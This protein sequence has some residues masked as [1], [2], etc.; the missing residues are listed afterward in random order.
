MRKIT[1]NDFFKNRSK[2]SK[3]WQQ[4]LAIGFGLMVGHISSAQTMSEYDFTQSSGTYTPLSGATVLWSG[5]DGFDDDA[6]TINLTT[7]FN[8]LGTNYSSI[9]VSAN[10]NIKFGSTSTT[11]TVISSGTFYAVA[12]FAVD[13]DAKAASAGTDLPSVSWKEEG[14]EVIIQWAN[15]CRYAT[16]GA[17][18]TS[19]ENL[20]FQ[21]RLNTSNSEIK[22][23]YGA[24]TDRVTPL[25]ST[26]PQV[27]LAGGSATSYSNRTIA[28]GGG[29]WI[30]STAGTA[31]GNTMAF[32]GSTIPS[33]GLT[34]KWTLPTCFT[35][36]GLTATTI[37]KNSALLQ[38]NNT[39]N[40]FDVEWGIEGFTPTNTPTAGYANIAG[41]S[42]TVS[43]LNYSTSYEYYLR[44]NC[45]DEGV[46]NWAGPYKFTTLC[47]YPDITNTTPGSV[48][49]LGEVNL[50]VS[51][52]A[53]LISWYNAPI[54]GVKLGEGN[55]FVTPTID[56]TTSYYVQVG[57]VTPGVITQVGNGTT[58]S[59][60]GGASP[61][62]RNWGGF[63]TQNI[64]RA[65]E[66]IAAGVA[67]GEIT[68]L[69]V[70]VTVAPTGNFN[71]LTI[72]VGHTT[73][74]VAT[75]THVDYNTLQLVY[76]NAS[77]SFTTGINT[78][79]FTQPFT[80]DGESNIV[81]QYN[82]SNEDS[83]S[84]SQ[85]KTIRYNNP[86]F[87]CTTYTYADGRTAD[88]ILNTLTGGVSNGSTTSGNTT[89]SSNRPNYYI[90]GNGLCAS[91]RVEVV[92]TVTTAPEL[93]L[94][95]N[96]VTICNEIADTVVT[97]ETGNDDYDT[98]TWEPSVNVSGDA[99]LGWTFS[100][101]ESA[102]YTLI[103]S[104]SIDGCAT[105]T[106]VNVI[107]T[108]G[109]DMTLPEELETCPENIIEL[110]SGVSTGVEE[111]I[112]E[113]F[114]NGTTFPTG[115][116]T[117][118]GAGDAI[119]IVNESTA[120]GTANQVK[121]TG[122][123]QTNPV[124]NRVY[125]GPI[126]TQGLQ[127]LTLTWNNYLNHY[128]ASYNYSAKIQTSSDGVTWNDTN[129]VYSPVTATQA[130]SVVNTVIST[131]DVGSST[132]Y[133]S[134]TLE[135]RTF[136][137]HNW[138]ID[139]VI[140]TGNFQYDVTWSPIDN[141]FIDAD[142]TI[143]Y[144]EGANNP[145]VYFMSAN[146][147]TFNYTATTLNE[148]GC[149]TT[150]VITITVNG[151]T[152]P[153]GTANQTVVEGTT[154]ADLA[155]VGENLVWYADEALT[156]E[157]PATTEVIDGTTYYV[158]SSNM[159]GDSSALA[160]TVTIDPCAGTPAPMAELVQTLN[161]G[162]TV[163]DIVVVG[164][165][166]T[167]YSDADLTTEVAETTVLEVGTYTFYVTQTIGDC[168]SEAI[169]IEVTVVDPCANTP[170]P[171]ADSP[172]AM[173]VGQTVAD[174]VVVGENLTW[175]SDEELTT[176]VAE[177]TVLE[178]G[179]YT[180]YVTQTI[181]DC[182]SEAIEVVVEVTLSTGGFDVMSF[183][184]YPN[185]VKDIFT[186]SYNKNIAEVTVVNMLGQIVAKQTVQSTD[187]QV[188]MSAL[189]AGNYVVKVAVDGAVQTLKVVKQ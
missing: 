4:M 12:A 50:A 162:Q 10:G 155:V 158:I 28:A 167:W 87:V 33:N 38:W 34:F 114:S 80:W 84:S 128:S 157:I 46:S 132:F 86:G 168:T 59:N 44:A 24:C 133:V 36:G 189:P 79:T 170:A 63:K 140:L 39:A 83:G 52:E 45:G 26:Y 141:L 51:T 3:R 99:T 126:N 41:T 134:F 117:V 136:G 108:E 188:D 2:K 62:A 100:A 144:T 160:I 69:G 5:Y 61:F 78:Y 88:Q 137:M 70:D 42:V 8:Y 112:N 43:G 164:E 102:I 31:A 77:Q 175:Y 93:A 109:P 159:C 154:L 181:G 14:N 104:N 169:A 184:A 121:I 17:G 15:V 182:T 19:T 29:D 98:F 107:V 171:T 1:L 20:N 13:L 97:I 106:E 153:T 54:G 32:N 180:F 166:L 187:A 178:E 27:G 125:Y 74:N 161:V 94:S 56:Q 30:N 85:A 143:P 58:T 127:E 71:N 135:G 95:S 148:L 81:I 57:N 149:D 163:A 113:T 146:A 37:T 150:S 6:T 82:F 89:S 92:A 122:N 64:I 47:N 11:N 118:V 9:F 147:N 40:M 115:W 116:H 68:S 22:I 173:T 16:L 73:N 18:A 174:I 101:P 7:P 35:P 60:S 176:E 179:S 76:S 130:A 65:S 119:A 186:I 21:I 25:T 53:D 152:T 156:N 145:I 66:L 91:P 165:N 138:N 151:I 75:S 183:K 185:P 55:S 96:N 120:G 48:C 177:T 90:N 172:Q 131:Q 124:I 142:A 129:W 110:N 123:S 139:N 72:Y 111:F 105:V 49:G 103:A 23:V 67:P